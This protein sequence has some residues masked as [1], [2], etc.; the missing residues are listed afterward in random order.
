MHLSFN[1]TQFLED[2]F[3]VKEKHLQ[4]YSRLKLFVL[5]KLLKARKVL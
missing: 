5:N 2:I 3:K 1:G 4:V